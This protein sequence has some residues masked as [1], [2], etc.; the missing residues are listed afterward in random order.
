MENP[1]DLIRD[2]GQRDGSANDPRIRAEMAAP[3]VFAEYDDPRTAGQ[4]VR[5]DKSPP[6]DRTQPEESWHFATGLNT[7]QQ[8][9]LAGAAECFAARAERAHGFEDV[10]P[11]IAPVDELWKREYGSIASAIGIE[12]L[13]QRRLRGIRQRSQ[14]NGV[15]DGEDCGRRTHA[16]RDGQSHHSREAGSLPDGPKRVPEVLKRRH[17]FRDEAAAATASWWL[18]RPTNCIHSREPV[19]DEVPTRE[20]WAHQIIRKSRDSLLA[21]AFARAANDPVLILFGAVDS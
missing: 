5:R 18:G 6:Q 17:L 1:D 16:K 14:E 11:A 8:L 3:Q 15:H 10:A 2:V 20:I 7:Q 21:V 12:Q 4:F 19:A 13:H 9:R